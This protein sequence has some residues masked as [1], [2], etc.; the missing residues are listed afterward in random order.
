MIQVLQ[1]YIPDIQ[2]N[3]KLFSSVTQLKTQ[4]ALYKAVQVDTHTFKVIENEQGIVG[5]NVAMKLNHKAADMYYEKTQEHMELDIFIPQLSLAFEYQGEHHFH[6]TPRFGQEDE[7]QERDKEKLELCAKNGITLIRVP[8][9]WDL[10]TASLMATIHRV[11]PGE[12]CSMSQ[13]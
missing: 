6:S 13:I 4:K 5:K 1:K 3:K 9:W 10:S 2:W 12:H 11:R 8:F 7:Y